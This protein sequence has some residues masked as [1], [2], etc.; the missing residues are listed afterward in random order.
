[1]LF[2][3]LESWPLWSHKIVL[4]KE[5]DCINQK[6]IGIFLRQNFK[7]KPQTDFISSMLEKQSNNIE[8]KFNICK[9]QNTFF[10]PMT[11]LFVAVHPK[12]EF[13]LVRFMSFMIPSYMG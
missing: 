2:F 12:V 13:N 5:K 6:S 11:V 4:I 10:I 1:M 7:E 8:N 9:P 3:F